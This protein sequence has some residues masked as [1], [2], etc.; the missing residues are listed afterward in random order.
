MWTKVDVYVCEVALFHFYLSEI[1]ND[2]SAGR[3]SRVLSPGRYQLKLLLVTK[4]T[5][6]LRIKLIDFLGEL[7]ADVSSKTAMLLYNFW[8]RCMPLK[9]GKD[10]IAWGYMRFRHCIC[11]SKQVHTDFQMNWLRCSRNSFLLCRWALVWSTHPIHVL[12]TLL[13][14]RSR[15]STCTLCQRKPAKTKHDNNVYDKET[16]STGT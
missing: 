13:T 12:F 7:T 2:R 15:A 11:Q 10:L 8:R 5:F 3:D 1:C 6:F 9:C 16:L 4:K 14:F